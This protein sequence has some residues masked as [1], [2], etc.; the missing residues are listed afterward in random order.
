MSTRVFNSFICPNHR[1]WLF[2]NP[3]AADHLY[4]KT[5]ESAGFY[6]EQGQDEQALACYGCA[7]ETSEMLLTM[8]FAPVHKAALRL[9]NSTIELCRALQR[10]HRTDLAGKYCIA[11]RDRLRAETLLHEFAQQTC[12]SNCIA[13][14]ERTRSQLGVI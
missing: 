7:Y 3:V 5:L 11:A 8:G 12:L 2:A 14:L 10:T 9:T 13:A 4:D 6:Q 1:E